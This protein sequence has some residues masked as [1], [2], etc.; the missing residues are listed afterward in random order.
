MSTLQTLKSE[1]KNEFGLTLRVYDGR[2]FADENATLASIRKGDSKGGEFSHKRNMKVGTFE[3]KMIELFGIKVQIAGS[4]DS[5]LCD[6]DLTLAGALEKDEQKMV[7]KSSTVSNED[8]QAGLSAEEEKRWLD[9]LWSLDEAPEYVRSNRDFMLKAVKEN[10]GVLEYASED[11]R[12]DREVILEAVKNHGS[13]LQYASEDIRVD[14]EIVLEAV[15]KDGCALEYASEDIRADKEIVLEAVKKNGWALEYASRDLRADKEIV[16]VAI[17]EDM[18]ALKYVLGELEKYRYT[19]YLKSEPSGEYWIGKLTKDDISELKEYCYD[20]EKY[21]ESEYVAD[22]S[23]Y[24]DIGRVWGIS[25]S[26]YLYS[27]YENANIVEDKSVG[28]LNHP[29]LD[30]GFYMLGSAPAKMSA[31][32]NIFVG[33]EGF[34]ISKLTIKYAKVNFPTS[35]SYGKI[36]DL[37]IINTIEYDGVDYSD[38][39]RDSFYDFDGYMYEFT[40]VKSDK[41]G[42]ITELVKNDRSGISWLVDCEEIG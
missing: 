3:N 11:L 20:E 21:E 29:T 4:D 27:E 38:A 9:D 34:D 35:D 37:Y 24:S 23:G 19:I 14:K 39:M 12:S 32:F 7:K 8:E 2:S 42:N 16:L 10:G 40:I 30:E 15:K 33:E 22:P 28:N 31:E 41:N 13:A 6:N 18:N 1:F 36:E 17:N 26:S 5:Y 25:L